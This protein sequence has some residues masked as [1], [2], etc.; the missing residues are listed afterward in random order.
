MS[1]LPSSGTKDLVRPPSDRPQQQVSLQAQEGR[2]MDRP[3]ELSLDASED[4][5]VR[6]F[7]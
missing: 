7:S 2:A 4:I 1:V 3:L 6:L 5:L